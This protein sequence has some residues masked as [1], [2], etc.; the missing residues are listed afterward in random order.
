MLGLILVFLLLP[1]QPSVILSGRN[2]F[3]G[4]NG[5]FFLNITT[6][7]LYGSGSLIRAITS[8]EDLIFSI[9]HLLGNQLFFVGPI[10]ID[11]EP[12]QLG[13]GGSIH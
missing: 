1:V 3:N 9:D 13:F 12:G 8:D 7:I 2:D 6:S 10:L 11:L 4:S 5:V